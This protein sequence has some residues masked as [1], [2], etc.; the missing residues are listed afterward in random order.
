MTTINPD[1]L[2]RTEKIEI[3][4]GRA[5]T[6]AEAKDLAAKRILQIFIAEDIEQSITKQA[7]LFTA[8]NAGQRAFGGGVHTHLHSNGTIKTPW[9][10]G[11]A[12]AEITRR[13]GAVQKQSLSSHYPTLVIGNPNCAIAGNPILYLTWNGWTAAVSNRQEH[14][15][16]DSFEF[17]LSGILSASLGISEAFNSSR[18]N[19][20]AGRRA[21]GLSLW[22]P[23]VE[24]RNADQGPS[25]YL[26]PQKLW[27]I[28]LGHLGQAYAWATGL[29][30]YPD[31]SQ[32][33]IVLQDDDTI[34][35][36][37]ISTGMLTH[38]EML[39]QKKT[40]VVAKALNEIGFRTHI[41]DKKFDQK[42][43]PKANDPDIAIAGLDNPIARRVLIRVNFSLIVDA[44]I[45]DSPTTFDDIRIHTFPS[46]LNPNTIWPIGGITDQRYRMPPAYKDLQNTLEKEQ[47][48][49]EAECGIVQLGNTAAGAAYV[50][51]A[52]ATLVLSE[53]IR[54]LMQ[55][56]RFQTISYNL[57]NTMPA[58]VAIN[59][60]QHLKT[61][62]ATICIK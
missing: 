22:D 62:P 36:A 12:I 19:R 28:G 39:C 50:G 27:L 58:K 1:N 33:D 3:D 61:N 57:R 4:S 53:I 23:H 14:R 11:L 2:D 24:W 42:T 55:R 6:F 40:Q 38:R 17:P 46:N 35:S 48:K 5:A 49:A 25:Q 8:I 32:I 21:V 60:I 52:T 18:G 59:P 51:C 13:L 37:N 16:T 34:V 9:S 20:I 30:P 47:S 43:R 41:I 26:L 10:K 54:T 44:G 31:P 7:M 15:L 45:G 56:P 29:L